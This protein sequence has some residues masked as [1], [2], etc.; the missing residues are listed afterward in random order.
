MTIIRAD[1]LK[2]GDIVAYD[3][4]NRRIARI[5]RLDGWAWPVATDDTGWAIALGCQ[6][7]AVH[8]RAA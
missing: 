1:E 4:R 5:D 8:Q 2:A 7:V 3:G 6:L